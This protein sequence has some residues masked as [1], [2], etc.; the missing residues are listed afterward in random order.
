MLR[1]AQ[2]KVGKAELSFAF[3]EVKVIFR[4]RRK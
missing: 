2:A 4:Q 3:G 1:F